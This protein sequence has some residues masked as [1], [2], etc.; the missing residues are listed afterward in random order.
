M[1]IVVK[2]GDNFIQIK[3]CICICFAVVLNSEVGLLTM[4]LIRTEYISLEV[5]LLRVKVLASAI[6]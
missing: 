2:R 6:T 1:S 5:N 3:S 4:F